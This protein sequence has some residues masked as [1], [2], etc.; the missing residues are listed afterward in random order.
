MWIVNLALRRPYTFVCIAILMLA[1]GVT[2]A[3]G[4]A[5]DIFP[6][7]NIPVVS[8]VWNYAGLSPRDME[9]RIV[10]V[11]ERT[12]SQVVANVEH[13]ESESLS[14][15][16]LIKVYLQPTADVAAAVA[17]LAAASQSVIRQMPPG[18]FP[19]YVVVFNATDVPIIQ[20]GISSPQRTEAQLNDLANN[21]VRTPLATIPG[22]TIPPANGGVSRVIQVDIDPFLLYANGLSAADIT[23][24]IAQQNVLLPSGTVKMGPVEY[25]VRL[26]STPDS[27]SV[28]ADMP[29]RQV[30]GR[31]IFVRDIA[32]V[33]DGSAIQTTIVRS[34]GHRGLYLTMLKN[35]NVSTLAVVSQLKA[36]LPRLKA[37][38][39]PDVELTLLA[40]QSIYV[41][42]AVTGVIREGVTA[43]ILT[44]LMILVFL[45]SV[46]ST[47]IVAVSIPLSILTSIIAVSRLGQTL[48]VMTLT[49]LAL[50]VGI[51]VDDATVAVE[52]IHRNI[53]QGKPLTQAIVDA[54]EQI[55]LPALVSTLSICIVFFPI[56]ALTGPA[57]ALFRPL[58]MAVIFAMLASYFLSRTLVPTMAQFMLKPKHEHVARRGIRGL[59]SRAAAAFQRAFEKFRGA[60]HGLL[61]WAMNNRR[62]VLPLTLVIVLATT[63]M[64]PRLGE[65]FFPQ[66]DGGQ[67]LLHMRAPTGTRVEQ[68]EVLVS[69]V[70][71][72][73]HEMIPP[74]E[75][76]LILSTIGA[77]SS[78]LSLILG[79]S[80]VG[81]ADADI[82]VQ[83]TETHTTSTFEYIRTLR[84]ALPP[85]FPGVV[86][87]SQPS[88][89]VNQ[90]LNLGVPAP[91]D[92]Q[93]SGPNLAGNFEA[94]R[95]LAGAVA[96]IPGS[97]DTRVQQVMDAPQLFLAA[98]RVRAAQVGLTPNVVASNLLISLSSNASTAPNF[99]LDPANGVQYTV[100][101]MTPQYKNTNM[102]LLEAT[103]I[104]TPANP[105]PQ[106]FGNLTSTTRTVIPGVVNH[107]NIM[108]VV[109][110]FLDAD[111]RDLGGVAND[112]NAAMAKIKPS[113]PA[114][115]TLALRGQVASMRSSF[116]GLEIGILFAVAL[117]YILLVVNF[118]SWLNPLIIIL[119]LPG[120]LT[121]IVWML[122]VTGTT[123]NVPSLM[124]AIMAMGVATANSVLLVTFAEARTK[125]GR[126]SREAA[127]DAGFAR[128]RPVCMTALAM[129]IGMAPMALGSGEGGEQYAPLGRA[130]IGGLV[131][132]TQFTLF[133]VPLMYATL[134]REKS[135]K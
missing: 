48:N 116:A 129:I 29:I 66:V 123:L 7:I 109:D 39:P 101:V 58:A 102:A 61:V 72:V 46:R 119:A 24:A 96:R 122:F 41:R 34:N 130:V 127:I 14:G 132:A 16:A 64:V 47:L 11:S 35:G 4:T 1:F 104:A 103:P 126:S 62:I 85:R 71:S 67:F 91:I 112:V 120:A 80:S 8:V 25:F 52:N 65:D 83:L 108:P 124:G 28:I 30:N 54:S 50:A 81:S 121:G 10:S 118:Q 106:L 117:V 56:F 98:D 21:F 31:T 128:L 12:Y 3:L 133:I 88:D 57:A 110:V 15:I 105:Q 18:V 40:D 84:G 111:Q 69:Q 9:Q 51:L 93:V 70:E 90:V 63:V 89:I 32:Q 42:A 33:H 22:L 74:S 37:T 6:A 68:T 86:F 26:N 113:L 95:R 82:L 114:G 73:I 134:R 135:G 44:A 94:A 75:L 45:G 76:T 5:V 79:S 13:I 49:G 43:A 19:P 60:Y 17:Q 97:A 38:L 125:A 23:T 78:G 53:Q 77:P 115:S 27:L 99:W 20:L 55:A 2:A 59:F 87:F 100:N 131:V 92:V 36:M 107:Y